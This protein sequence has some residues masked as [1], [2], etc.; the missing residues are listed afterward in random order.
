LD[1]GVERETVD[2][3][4]VQPALGVPPGTAVLE[5]YDAESESAELR[6]SL[7][8]SGMDTAA[9]TRAAQAMVDHGV[10]TLGLKQVRIRVPADSDIRRACETAGFR[11][12]GSGQEEGDVVELVAHA[13]RLE[14][15]YPIE[16]ERLLLRPLDPD[17]D[18]APMHAYRSRE[19]VC[20]YVP[21]V[22]GTLG[23]MRERLADPERTRSVIDA[24]GQVLS[25][26][27]ERRDAG[28]MIG[29]LVLF[30]HSVA[31]GHAEVGYVVHPDHAGQGFAT[32]ATAALIDLA[33]YGGLPV[34]RVTARLD[35]RHA[36]SAAV[37]RRLGL[38]QEAAF[39]EGEWFK[40]EWTT[41]LIFAVLEHEWRARRNTVDS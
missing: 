24:E 13:T 37:C 29:D 3:A 22:P 27:I 36:A 18:V 30:W 32:E 39:V 8:S 16:T 4:S 19:D 33:F 34:H 35:E 5:G 41:L 7:P 38:R 26:A 28:E 1:G 6:L 15:D 25:L 9:A 11:S 31:D 17:A 23:Q 2:L 12:A 21:F 40:G 10:R 20:R 14:P